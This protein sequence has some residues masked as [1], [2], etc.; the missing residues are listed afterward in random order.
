[1]RWCWL[2]ALHIWTE[3]SGEGGMGLV[4]KSPAHSVTSNGHQLFF[5]ETSV[6]SFGLFH[7]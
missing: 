3:L 2:L 6:D 7:Y 1:V 4:N 5:H